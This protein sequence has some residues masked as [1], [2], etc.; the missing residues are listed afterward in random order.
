MKMKNDIIKRILILFISIITVI[1]CSRD[2]IVLKSEHGFPDKPVNLVMFNS[3]YDDYNSD[4]A[5]GEYDMYPLIFSSNRNSKGRNY[6]FNI[7]SLG[8]GYPFDEDI[9]SIRE[10]A[11]ITSTH[12][13]LNQI[14]DEVNTEDNQFGPYIYYL[15]ESSDPH[16][17]E[18]LF[19]YA[20]GKPDELDIKY[21]F[22]ELTK[23]PTYQDK[24]YEYKWSGPFDLKSINTDNFSEGYIS[25]QSD[26]IHFCSN[27]T[28]NYDIYEKEIP[29]S[30]SI[31][32]FLNSENNGD[33]I[34]IVE[35]NSNAD[36]K[37]PFIVDNFMVFASDREGGFGGF[38]LWYSVNE[39]GIWSS[40]VNFG[41]NIN[42][43]FDEYRPI[44]KKYD[45]IKNDIMIFSSN[46]PGGK[47]GFDLYYIGIHE[48]KSLL[49]GKN[50]FRP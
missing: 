4:I 30:T 36:D 28:G 40:P 49:S 41:E 25:I 20:Q 23:A 34:Q 15:P 33:F 31:F 10:S 38:D 43:D 8:M 14:I 45:D 6:D 19:F 9:V 24:F 50:I 26:K 42:S 37:C 2:D 47:G 44:F 16:E 1:S 32:E 12:S 5:P 11:G 29:S 18:F 27:R 48:T 13:H 22:H 39:N 21:W 17:E 3:K 35:L 7:F 46:R